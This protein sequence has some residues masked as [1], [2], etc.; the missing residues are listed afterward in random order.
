MSPPAGPRIPKEDLAAWS[1]FIA[2]H[3]AVIRHIEETLEREGV[4]PLS[5]Y[6]VLWPLYRSPDKRLR[7]NELA[8][9]VVLSR[10]ALVRLVDRIERAGLLRREP[11]PEDGRG[12]YAVITDQG[13]DALR[14]IWPV[15]GREIR[16]LFLQPLGKDLSRV[17][18]GMERIKAAVAERT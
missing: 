17:R 5:W 7:M 14:A 1:A 12:T 15:Y 9:D 4:P 10:T 2:G 11:V 3:A 16:A 13:V 18:A 8:E 6:D